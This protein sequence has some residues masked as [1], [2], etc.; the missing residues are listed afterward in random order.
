[1]IAV[2]IFAALGYVLTVVSNYYESDRQGNNLAYSWFFAIASI[3]FY[4]AAVVRFIV[5]VW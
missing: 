2:L 3:V 1:M 5:W 4:A